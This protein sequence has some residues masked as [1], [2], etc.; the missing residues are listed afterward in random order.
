MLTRKVIL[1]LCCFLLWGCVAHATIVE[2]IT[3]AIVRVQWSADG[4]LSGNS[5]GLC[6]YKP[7]HVK[8]KR[9]KDEESVLI[10]ASS[11][12]IVKMNL[13]NMEDVFDTETQTLIITFID[14]NSGKVLLQDVRRSS[15]N[16]LNVKTHSASTKTMVNGQEMV[17]KEVIHDTIENRAGHVVD[18][19]CKG[20][21]AL[22]G[23]GV[24]MADDMNLMGKTLYITQRNPKIFV[25]MLVSPQGYGVL[26]DA[27]GSMKFTSKDEQFSMFTEDSKQVDYYFIKGQRMQDIVS[28]CRYLTGK[29]PLFPLYAFGYYENQRATT[30]SQR[31]L[32]LARSSYA[33]LQR[34]SKQCLTIGASEGRYKGMSK[35]T[36]LKVVLP[37][38]KELSLTYRGKRLSV[39]TS[40]ITGSVVSCQSVST[41]Q[42]IDEEEVSALLKSYVRE[43]TQVKIKLDSVPYNDTLNCVYENQLHKIMDKYSMTRRECEFNRIPYFEWVD[44]FDSTLQVKRVDNESRVFDISYRLYD[45]NER[46]RIFRSTLAHQL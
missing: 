33:G 21:K 13:E 46:E 7:Q 44:T 22:Y 19:V 14:K 16:I 2:F 31:V 32:H 24:R 17:K 30:N 4:D 12:L 15:R 26:F 36:A 41:G 9:L 6:I 37:N 10:I 25:P 18:F 11:E 34:D 42:D 20:T 45:R 23:L 27:G 40:T 28:G 29:V 38:G 8:V 39:Y 5:T 1:C 35:T 43:Y 3:P